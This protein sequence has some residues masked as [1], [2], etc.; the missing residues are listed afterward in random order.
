ME[1]RWGS[2]GLGSASLTNASDCLGS[3]SSGCGSG[4][5]ASSSGSGSGSAIGLASGSTPFCVSNS[6]GVVDILAGMVRVYRRRFGGREQKNK[7]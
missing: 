7:K 2:S 4:T 1:V 3:A 5:A 6:S